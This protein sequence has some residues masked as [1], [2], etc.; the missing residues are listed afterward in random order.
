MRKF[1]PEGKGLLVEKHRR[2]VFSC[3]GMLVEGEELDKLMSG[4]CAAGCGFCRYLPM[5]PE[6]Q[7][8]RNERSDAFEIVRD[9]MHMYL[10]CRSSP[11]NT[12]LLARVFD[13]DLALFQGQDTGDPAHVVDVLKKLLGRVAPPPALPMEVARTLLVSL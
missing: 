6:G 9:L 1:T 2:L 12:S 5:G 7:V 8:A 11:M 13:G 4:G 3:K 10:N